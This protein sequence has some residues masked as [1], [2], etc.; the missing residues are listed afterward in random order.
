MCLVPVFGQDL[1]KSNDSYVVDSLIKKESP[2]F[3]IKTIDGRRY[4]RDHEK[5]K[6]LVIN[7]WFIGCG[8]CRKELPQLNELVVE[9]RARKDIYFISISNIDT[10]H[11]L[12]YVRKRLNLKFQLVAK[13]TTIVRSFG[14]QLYP[15]NIVI[16]KNGVVV[17]AE[18]GYQPGIKLRLQKIL[19]DAK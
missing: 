19:D 16:D 4:E 3:S 14:V 10:K 18:I 11:S 15:T 7:F 6:I 2:S 17:F 5:G 1:E 8:P 13:D 9:N 12:E